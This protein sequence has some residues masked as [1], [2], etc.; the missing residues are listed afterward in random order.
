MSHFTS[1]NNEFQKVI[2]IYMCKLNWPHRGGYKFYIWEKPRKF[3]KI[4][5]LF[6]IKYSKIYSNGCL[7]FQ[8]LK[9]TITIH[10]YIGQ[11][12]HHNSTK[13]QKPFENFCVLRI[14]S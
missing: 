4:F 5:K 2:T 10:T 9:I 1:H 13:Y 14:F 3:T 12:I 8:V 6:K 7:I 11:S